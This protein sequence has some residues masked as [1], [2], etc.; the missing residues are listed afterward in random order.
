ML[1]SPDKQ[2]VIDLKEKIM[3]V[4]REGIRDLYHRCAA[5]LQK[6]RGLK[7]RLYVAGDYSAKEGITLG[8]LS[9]VQKKAHEIYI[10][11]EEY[12]QTFTDD[13][14]DLLIKAQQIKNIKH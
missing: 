4:F 11:P 9:E 8:D 12:G 3:V 5:E 1:R 7:E 14:T 13:Q 10:A 2:R 6:K